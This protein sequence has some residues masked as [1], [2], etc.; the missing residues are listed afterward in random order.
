[1]ICSF[2]AVTL[3]PTALVIWISFQK[4]RFYALEGFVGFANYGA[5]LFSPQFIQ[6]S[7]NSLLYV[8]CSLAAVLPL[9]LASALLL[10]SLGRLGTALRVA[11]LVVPWTLSMAVVGAFSRDGIPKGFSCPGLAV[12]R[13]EQPNFHVDREAAKAGV[14]Q[15]AS[16]D[17]FG[18]ERLRDP[19]HT[20]ALPRHRQQ[21]GCQLSCEPLL[22]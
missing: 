8:L 9:G 1:M 6:V 19:R 3:Y 13:P 14:N 21:R 12:H 15:A 22:E 4:T 11:L 16:F 7:M 2:V 5:V 17:V 18:R 20:F 10:Q